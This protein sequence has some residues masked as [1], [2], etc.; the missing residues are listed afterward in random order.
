MEK[1]NVGRTNLFSGIDLLDE[2][3][4][5]S[6]SRCDVYWKNVYNHIIDILLNILEKTKDDIQTR[7]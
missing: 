5:A 2:L 4:C 6:L 1:S 7:L 3:T